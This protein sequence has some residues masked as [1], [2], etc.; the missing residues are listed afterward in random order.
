MSSQTL[1]LLRLE[2]LIAFSHFYDFAAVIIIFDITLIIFH[3]D[4]SFCFTAFLTV[5]FLLFLLYAQKTARSGL[6][7][8][9]GGICALTVVVFFRFVSILDTFIPA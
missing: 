1:T 7:I 3:V 9:L 5:L 2:V 6:H 8:L 4:I